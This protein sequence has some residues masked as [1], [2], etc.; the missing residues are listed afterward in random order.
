M[1][2]FKA[3]SSIFSFLIIIG[4]LVGIVSVFTA[5]ISI[6][7]GFFGSISW[8]GW[9]IVRSGLDQPDLGNLSSN[10]VQWMPLVVLLFSV[11]A[12]LI[13]LAALVKPRKEM[14]IGAVLCG[15]ITIIAAALFYL[16]GDLSGVIGNGVYIAMAA[17]AIMFIFGALRLSVSNDQ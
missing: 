14:G 10:Y 9:E 5:W 7:F 16:D 11:I 15:I 17:G 2:D 13:G 4:A 8:S 1:T 12:L 6:D 3:K